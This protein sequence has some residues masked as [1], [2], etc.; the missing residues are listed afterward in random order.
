VDKEIATTVRDGMTS[1]FEMADSALR[2]LNQNPHD[3]DTTD[4]IRRLFLAKS[5]QDINNKDSMLK[6]RRIFGNIIKFYRTEIDTTASATGE[7]IVRI[8]SL[9][10][11][12]GEIRLSNRPR[13]R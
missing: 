2:H 7:D 8:L 11:Y 12:I 5:G 3:R 9:L 6:V 1:A 10:T 13:N 4:L